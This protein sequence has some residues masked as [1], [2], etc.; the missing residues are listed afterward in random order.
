MK[1]KSLLIFACI[2]MMFA[3]CSSREEYA[4]KEDSYPI[5]L[6]AGIMKA[7]TRAIEDDL[8]DTK[9]AEG[10]AISVF[11]TKTGTST[12]IDDTPEV[13]YWAYTIDADLTSMSLSS[14]TA[15]Q[16]P[17]DGTA[18]DVYALHPKMAKSATF[19][20][21]D[22][23]RTLAKYRSSD[24]MYANA[25]GKKV[26][27]GTV[28]LLFTHCLSKVVI[29]VDAGSSGVTGDISSLVFFTWNQTANISHDGNTISISSV[30]YNQ[31]RPLYLYKN[32]NTF[33]GIMMPH[34]ANSDNLNCK[35]IVD[36]VGK[37]NC[38]F[39]AVELVAG[40]EHHITITI[41]SGGEA[42]VKSVGISPWVDGTD[43]NDI[44]GNYEGA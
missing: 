35:F 5:S 2:G 24:L 33:Y 27:D 26:T 32:G 16:F 4:S 44:V 40:S 36:G 6:K 31:S 37:Y 13:G 20:I 41:G 43:V 30:T 34:T 9:F 3:A 38:D 12:N 18:V 17:E 19:S 28:E 15:P 10:E 11:V 22:D 29:T 1:I 7:N 23:Q 14:G 8:Q 25:T 21:N 39:S 42:K